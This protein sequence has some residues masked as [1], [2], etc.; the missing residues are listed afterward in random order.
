MINFSVK[1]WNQV[2]EKV[3]LSCFEFT[4][5]G[6]TIFGVLFSSIDWQ[7]SQLG[8]KALFEGLYSGL[9]GNLVGVLPFVTTLLSHLNQ[10]F[11][12]CDSFCSC[13]LSYQSSSVC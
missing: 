9:A 3:M 10:F 12:E 1:S 2:V 4:V 8:G 7:A 6:F 11:L 5:A 13:F